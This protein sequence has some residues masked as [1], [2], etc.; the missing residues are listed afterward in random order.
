MVDSIELQT[1]GEKL[2]KV[3]KHLKKNWK[4]YALG[5]PAGIAAS[6]LLGKVTADVSTLVHNA[7]QKKKREEIQRKE[8]AYQK[9]KNQY[10]GYG[11]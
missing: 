11:E 1:E 9:R 7:S 5:I 8:A 10:K 2:D 3:K 4:K 6:V